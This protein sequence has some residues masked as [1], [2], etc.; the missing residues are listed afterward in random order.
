MVTAIIASPDRLMCIPR[1]Q[2]KVTVS[3]DCALD[4][5]LFYISSEVMKQGESDEASYEQT[6]QGDHKHHR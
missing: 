6:D 4:I 3:H 1:D 5:P 2:V